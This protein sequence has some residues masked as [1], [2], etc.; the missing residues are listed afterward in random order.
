MRPKVFSIFRTGAGGGGGIRRVV[1]CRGDKRASLKRLFRSC[2][3]TL[4][5][6][7]ISSLISETADS[8]SGK[9]DSDPR[10]Q[11]WQGC[12]LPTELFPQYAIPV[13]RIASAKVVKKSVYPNL[14]S[15]FCKFFRAQKVFPEYFHTFV[16]KPVPHFPRA[17]PPACRAASPCVRLPPLRAVSAFCVRLRRSADGRAGAMPRDLCYEYGPDRRSVQGRGPGPDG[18]YT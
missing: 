5:K 7:K 2:I 14:S 17:G 3:S 12:A 16:E 10:P 11:P 9:R 13:S 18:V 8:R 15:V 4:C 1:L 6:Q